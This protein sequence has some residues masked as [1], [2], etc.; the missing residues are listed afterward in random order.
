[1]RA[2]GLESRARLTA[3]AFG[4]AERRL[5][6]LPAADG[7]R[8]SYMP[9]DSGRAEVTA[10]INERPLAPH[11][12]WT[13]A[14]MGARALID[15]ETRLEFANML[16]AGDLTFAGWR[17]SMARPRV[18]VGIALPSPGR[19]PGIVSFDAA[20]ERQSY[21]SVA[22]S[23][24]NMTD[25][26]S[27]R[28]AGLHL[29]DWATDWL[30]WQVG[31]A[32]DRFGDRDYASADAAL[33]LRLLHDHIAIASSAAWWRPSHTGDDLATASLSVG[34][35]STD[36]QTHTSLSSRLTFATAT[37]ASPRALWP[38]AGTGRG[39]DLL[40]RAH[41]LL[42]DDVMDG[43]AF[44]RTVSH[45][46]MELTR[47]LARIPG[48]AVA[49]AAFV[50]SARVWHRTAAAVTSPLYLDV[51][52]GVRLRAPGQRNVVRIDLAHGLLGGGFTLSAGW[53]R[54]WFR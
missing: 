35:R 28:R 27:R 24:S 43:D 14:A 48:G 54:A 10:S 7:A 21:A 52:V 22:T 38:G 50:D 49:M 5:Q 8:V 36:D 2:S 1:M 53:T 34:W 51:G 44:G 19:L 20:W 12:W 30:R 23:D 29:E 39:R 15:R 17:W 3:A 45:G 42:H 26:E 6:A 47:P 4:R 31:A 13:A 40:L 16:R 46:S 25:R 18:E 37:I 41:P 33:D 32:L 9:M 11:G